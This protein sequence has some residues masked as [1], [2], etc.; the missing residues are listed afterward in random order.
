MKRKQ[1]PTTVQALAA[2]VIVQTLIIN[3][4]LGLMEAHTALV[5][6]LLLKIIVDL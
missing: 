3:V 2:I 1:F 5:I 4:S 6:L